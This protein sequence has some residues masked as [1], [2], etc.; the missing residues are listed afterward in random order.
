MA[1]N[2]ITAIRKTNPS[3]WPLHLRDLNPKKAIK[4]TVLFQFLELA[5]TKKAKKAYK[6][7]GKLRSTEHFQATY[8]KIN[9]SSVYKRNGPAESRMRGEKLI[10][11]NFF[12]KIVNLAP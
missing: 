8:C 7:Y 12:N 1:K 6:L 10:Y 9:F 5:L 11:L 2:F 3:S 4:R